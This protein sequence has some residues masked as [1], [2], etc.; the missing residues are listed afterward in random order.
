[1]HE[2]TANSPV[3][4]YL[5]AGVLLVKDSILFLSFVNI[6]LQTVSVLAVFYT[7][8]ML[9]RWQTACVAG[10]LF[11]CLNFVVESSF[12]LWQPY[13]MQAFSIFSILYLVLGYMKKRNVWLC[14]SAAL[15]IFSITLHN[16][17]LALVPVYVLAVALILF[18]RKAR[19]LEYVYVGVTALVTAMALYA[20]LIYYFITTPQSGYVAAN[21]TTRFN[22]FNIHNIIEQSFASLQQYISTS[23]QVTDTTAVWWLIVLCVTWIA[24][25]VLQNDGIKKTSVFLLGVALLSNALAIGAIHLYTFQPNT[26]FTPVYALTVLLIAELVMGLLPKMCLLVTIRIIIIV[27]ILSVGS[28][29]TYLLNDTSHLIQTVRFRVEERDVQVRVAGELPYLIPTIDM[30]KKQTGT[31]YGFRYI[32]YGN[33]SLYTDMLFYNALE[34]R[35]QIPFV[36]II[37]NPSHDGY[38]PLGSDQFFLIRCM[39]ISP[40]ACAELFSNDHKNQKYSLA[41]IQFESKYA[42]YLLAKKGP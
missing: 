28:N 2:K 23:F 12:G 38:V 1:M 22:D 34:K 11:A 39:G 7:A 40:D 41:K 3:Y 14:A 16:S 30:L 42:T 13:L 33:T 15:F 26:Y 32:Q 6:F 21:V 25:L 29:I 8:K 36:K 4:Y 17:L 20:P 24:Y 37:D 27:Y 35:Y 19:A 31:I 18:S 5:L 9:F 10:F